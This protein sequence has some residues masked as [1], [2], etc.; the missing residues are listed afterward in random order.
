MCDDGVAPVYDT[1]VITAFVEHSHVQSEHIRKING[2]VCSALVRAD[3][4]HVIA[5]DL[6]ILHGAEQTFDKLIGRLHSFK[7]A[8]RDSILYSRVMCV[9]CDDVV[10]AHADELL[11]CESAV[12]RF[13]GTSLVL[14]ALIEER[15]D[16]VDTASLSADSGN[17]PFQILEMIVRRHMIRVSCQRVGYTVVADIYHQVEI[18]SADRLG[19]DAFCLSGTKTRNLCVDKK[20]ILLI[21]GESDVVSVLVPAFVAPFDEIII[22]LFPEF[23][24]SGEGDKPETSD[25]NVF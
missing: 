18:F 24:A 21:S 2:T 13:T 20:S 8:E 25:R 23:L 11:K 9:E 4:H 17:D 3:R 16:D 10:Y 19:D 12:Q 14:T 22:N 6:K 5:V 1:G 15:H 7:A